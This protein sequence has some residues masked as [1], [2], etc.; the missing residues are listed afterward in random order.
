MGYDAKFYKAYSDFLKDRSVRK[1][2]E[3]VLMIVAT[4]ADFS[5]VIDL[6]C[7]Q[8]QEFR[9]YGGCAYYKGIDLNAEDHLGIVKG[10]Y[11]DWLTLRREIS[12]KQKS[13]VSLFSSE[14]TAPYQENYK[15]YSFIFKTFPHIKYGLVSGFYYKSRK[16][17]NPILETGSITRYQTLESIEDCKRVDFTERRIILPVPSKMFGKDVI[18]VWKFFE[19]TK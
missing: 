18:E 10:N 6:G 8:C 17:Q 1:A 16:H 5:D 7:G 15:L 3:F 9:R 13:F 19:R 2:H 11:R 14:I 4:Q 12:K